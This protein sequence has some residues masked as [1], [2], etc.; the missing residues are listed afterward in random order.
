LEAKLCRKP[1][2]VAEVAPSLEAELVVEDIPRALVLKFHTELL[3]ESPEESAY[4]ILPSTV[5]VELSTYAPN[6]PVY[7]GN[8]A[9]SSM[10]SRRLESGRGEEV[11]FSL[12]L[13]HRKVGEIE[14]A[15]GKGDVCL[16]VYLDVLVLIG[17]RDGGKYR[18]EGYRCKVRD[19]DAG[20][21]FI[22]IAASDWISALERAR[23]GR[24]LIFD[25]PTGY[26]ALELQE[27]GL[28]SRLAEASKGVEQVLA[29]FDRQSWDKFIK[30]SKKFFQLLRRGEVA[31]GISTKEAIKELIKGDG[32]DLPQE[33]AQ[34][35]QAV[36]E[37]LYRFVNSSH[38]FQDENG[39]KMKMKPSYDKEDALFIAV[40][41]PALL[42]MLSRKFIKAQQQGC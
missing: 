25:I 26:E 15:R 24:R 20:K 13:E 6:K 39:K 23:C 7:L 21:D 14:Q 9:P 29:D 40:V 33:A 27:E 5:S 42:N 2:L 4:T 37:N 1:E 8:L 34:S 32:S 28:G 36:V 30:D 18:M 17:D 22:K 16:D 11:I 10:H 12:E 31:Q 3:G 41:V 19:A 35:I 38:R